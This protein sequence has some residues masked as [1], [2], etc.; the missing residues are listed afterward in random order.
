MSLN[1]PVYKCGSHSF[2]YFCLMVHVC[3]VNFPFQFWVHHVLLYMLAVLGHMI[4]IVQCLPITFHHLFNY[5]VIPSLRHGLKLLVYW[6]LWQLF[7]RSRSKWVW[8]L[9]RVWV[10]F[11]IWINR[12][13]CVGPSRL[14]WE[15]F[16]LAHLIQPWSN[17]HWCMSELLWLVSVARKRWMPYRIL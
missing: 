1:Q 7:S 6:N 9:F 14:L 15:V 12:S 8:R 11:S 17:Y 4:Y 13:S 3:W 16:A 10:I 2:L 5:L